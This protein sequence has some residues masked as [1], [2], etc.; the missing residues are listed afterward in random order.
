MQEPK[1]HLYQQEYEE[2]IKF[3][4]GDMGAYDHIYD[5]PMNGL[6]VCDFCKQVI[7]Q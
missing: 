6:A 7:T 4:N 3:D 2:E 1:K 5:D